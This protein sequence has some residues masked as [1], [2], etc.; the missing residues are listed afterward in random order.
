[1]NFAKVYMLGNSE[2]AYINMDHITKVRPGD[3]QT[4]VMFNNGD[5]ILIEEPSEVMDCLSVKDHMV[6]LPADKED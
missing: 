1:M 5:E 6:D 3:S 2:I 4:V